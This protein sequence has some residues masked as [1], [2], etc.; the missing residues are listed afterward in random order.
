MLSQIVRPMI[1]AQ[2]RLLLS[3]VQSALRVSQTLDQLTEHL[4]PDLVVLALPMALSIALLDRQI[5]PSEEQAL[6]WLYQSLKQTA[7]ER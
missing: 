3:G 7:P 1:Q 2:L 5:S 4:D 6:S